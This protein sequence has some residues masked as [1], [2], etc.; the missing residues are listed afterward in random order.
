MGFEA[1]VNPNYAAVIVKVPPA[2]QLE[3][4]D[5]LVGVPIFGY[6]V[7]TQ[8]AGYI[9]GELRVLFLA[10]TQLDVE[11]ARENNLY[12]EA[13]LNKNADETGYLEASGR[14][15]AIRLRKNQSDALLMPLESLAYTGF[16]VSTLKVGDTF[17]KLNGH[18]ICRKY[19]IPRKGGR[20]A[21]AGPKIRSGV[22][23]KLF[24]QHLDTEHLFRNLHR[25]R[26]QQRIVITQ[27][28]HGTSARFGR[29]PVTRKLTWFERV[30]RYYGWFVKDTEYEL[31][32]GS[33]RAIKGKSDG[34]DFYT[35]D[36]WNE[37]AKRLE[38]VIPDGWVVYGEL[39]GWVDEQTPIQR[40]YT[41]N[42]PAGQIEFYVYRVATVN[43]RGIVADVSW[44]GVK[45]FCAS[46][47]LKHVPELWSGNEFVL[48]NDEDHDWEDQFIH[49]YQ[50]GYLDK[51]L[52]EEF[53]DQEL[54]PLSDPKTVDEGVCVRVEGLIPSI[55]KAKSPLFLAHETKQ[56]DTGELTVDD[57]ELAA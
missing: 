48:P 19:E 3:G 44:E 7:L 4:L 30:L 25:F 29:I 34:N 32:P 37:Y 57:Y 21:S 54:V 8:R 51:R 31:L 42:L 49:E 46:A 52:A 22:D 5:N 36:V 16:D 39:I 28:L 12:R 38:G 20:G 6:Q 41:Y 53:P 26:R 9:P 10:E 14:V 55:F 17:D 13:T 50:D 40:G 18:T 33:R 35:T 2:I 45:E 27:K 43:H 15:K 56:L 24:P 47:G 1:P 23:Q 11:Y